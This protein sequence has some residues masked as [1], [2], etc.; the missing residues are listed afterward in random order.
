MATTEEWGL[1]IAG[2]VLV[3]GGIGYALDKAGILHVPLP[4]ASTATKTYPVAFLV[5]DQADEY[6]AQHIST[7]IPIGALYYI[8]SDPE[9]S[10]ANQPNEPATARYGPPTNLSVYAGPSKGQPANVVFIG[11]AGKVWTNS[12]K[13]TS[14]MGG[15]VIAN[16]EGVNRA[17]TR[18]RLT[19]LIQAHP[20]WV[21]PS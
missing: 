14:W 5:A 10:L 3:L 4:G 6:I 1:G 13:P 16:I 18:N 20:T 19:A 2:A 17:D 9:Q 7:P 12:N 21:Q 8:G 15:K 11:A